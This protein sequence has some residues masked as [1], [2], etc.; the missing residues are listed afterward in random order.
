MLF[1]FSW[2]DANQCR[3][4]PN[5]APVTD[6]RKE[7]VL[8]Q[9]HEP[10]S[11]RFTHGNIDDKKS[12]IPPSVGHDLLTGVQMKSHLWLAFSFLYAIISPQD[13]MQ[14]GGGRNVSREERLDSP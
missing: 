12:C 3:F 7:S 11:L 2:G 4:T 14:L 10:M 5:R 13:R 6:K 9:L 8:V 1:Y